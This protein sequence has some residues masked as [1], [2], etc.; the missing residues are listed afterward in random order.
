MKVVSGKKKVSLPQINISDYVP[1]II[2]PQDVQD[3]VIPFSQPAEHQP[4]PF[5]P[6]IHI[7]YEPSKTR[8]IPITK[9]LGEPSKTLAEPKENKKTMSLFSV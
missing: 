8:M 6:P 9:P 3:F 4:I 5:K 1:Y 7:P 2:V